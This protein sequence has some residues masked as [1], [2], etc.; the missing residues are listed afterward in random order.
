MD[1]LILPVSVEEGRAV[2]LWTIVRD[3][4]PLVEGQLVVEIVGEGAVLNVV[5]AVPVF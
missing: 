2:P 1:V 4:V 5:Q 3:S